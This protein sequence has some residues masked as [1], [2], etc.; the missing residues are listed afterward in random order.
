MVG[1]RWE[2]VCWVYRP[3]ILL[4]GRLGWYRCSGIANE[5]DRRSGALRARGSSRVDPHVDKRQRS[6]SEPVAG[7]G[8]GPA[9][10]PKTHAAISQGDQHDWSKARRPRLAVILAGRLRVGPSWRRTIPR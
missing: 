5:F 6:S 7:A 2:R 3:A 8:H 10:G 1:I 4:E 9:G